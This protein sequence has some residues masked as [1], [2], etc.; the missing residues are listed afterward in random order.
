VKDLGPF[1]DLKYVEFVKR[2]RG[3]GGGSWDVY[4]RKVPLRAH[5][6]PPNVNTG[7]F[8]DW[9]RAATEALK[10]AA[11]D[12]ASFPALETSSSMKDGK[13]LGDKVRAGVDWGAFPEEEGETTPFR[14]IMETE[15]KNLKLK[16]MAERLFGYMMSW[17]YTA[18]CVGALVCDWQEATPTAPRRF[19]SLG[20]VIRRNLE[21]GIPD[22]ERFFNL[23][24][25]NADSHHRQRISE[26]YS[27]ARTQ[28]DEK[29]MTWSVPRPDVS[30]RTVVRLPS[31]TDTPERTVSQLPSEEYPLPEPQSWL[32]DIPN[33]LRGYYTVRISAAEL[34]YQ[35]DL[36]DAQLARIPPFFLNLYE[37]RL[38]WN[39]LDGDWNETRDAKRPRLV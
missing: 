6:I 5:E 25:A 36:S 15:V 39:I 16:H 13:V 23:G 14:V 34:F 18:V 28:V 7:D 19:V 1:E 27:W 8:R 33:D 20:V 32:T 29:E 26:L 4:L 38:K 9:I 24:T 11:R 2:G 21:T 35:C 37:S 12:G 3:G 30:E 22:F 10:A 31:Q 17:E